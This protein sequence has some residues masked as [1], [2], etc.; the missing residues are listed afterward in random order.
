MR[1]LTVSLPSVLVLTKPFLAAA[2][3]LCLALVVASCG[4]ISS[5][6][7]GGKFTDKDRESALVSDHDR[8]LETVWAR[9]KETL[10]HLSTRVP[11]FDEATRRAY[12]TVDEGSIRTE[13]VET[14]PGRTR[15]YMKARRYGKDAPELARAVLDRIDREIER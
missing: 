8:D 7:L 4:S 10:A 3:A 9:V 14:R 11:R 13:V 1:I 6:G 15:V 5:G 12:A 2:G